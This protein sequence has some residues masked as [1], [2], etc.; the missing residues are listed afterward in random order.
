MNARLGRRS[1]IGNRLSSGLSRCWI[2]HK[3]KM[4]TACA[5]RCHFISNSLKDFASHNHFL[6]FDWS[7]FS[8][9]QTLSASK[10][11]SRQSMTKR[12]I[13]ALICKVL[14]LTL[15]VGALNSVTFLLV[16]FFTSMTSPG[17]SGN[18]IE[19]MAR[20]GSIVN[21]LPFFLNLLAAGVL[22]F[23]ADKLAAL[24]VKG[25]D[26]PLSPL[27][28]G[29]EAQVLAFSSLGLFSLLQAIP[30]IGQI[31]VSLYILRQQDSLT[32]REFSGLTGPEVASVLIQLGLGF[33]LLL[34]A[35][36]LARWVQSLRRVGVDK[37][38]E[39]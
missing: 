5:A 35:S 15:F 18:D 6:S 12:E 26:A 25:D 2:N 7:L 8:A 33:W 4:A 11:I 38:P 13:A 36:G 22:W 20:L 21:A 24:M 9:Y 17:L 27:V 1:R 32:H 14:S 10:I 37:V 19:R 30:R 39:N 29:P 31:V 23:Q 28:V 3:T 16:P 34:G